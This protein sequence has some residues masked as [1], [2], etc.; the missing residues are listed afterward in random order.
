MNASER[1]TK[2]VCAECEVKY[3]DLNKPTVACPKCGTKPAPR[4]IPRSQQ[5]A[6]KATGSTFRRF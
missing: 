3:Y 1:G 2:H 5:S 4:K 6:K